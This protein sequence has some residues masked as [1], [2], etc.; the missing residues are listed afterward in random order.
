M[1]TAA[2]VVLA[3]APDAFPWNGAQTLKAD[4]GTSLTWTVTRT[5]G[6]VLIEGTHSRWSV[7]HVAKLD[8]TPVSTVKTSNGKT[9]RIAYREGGADFTPPGGKAVLKI[10]A[11]G[12]WDSE[13]L[14][15]RLAGIRWSK[16]KQL[17]FNVLDVDSSDGSV[18]PMLAEGLGPE[19]CGGRACQGV[20][21]TL[22]GWRRP[23]GPTIIF[24]YG[25]DEAAAYLATVN[26]GKELTSR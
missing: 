15:A 7:V 17:R 8:G 25:T 11:N 5:Q 4:D 12:L 18:Y 9:A 1:L 16:G 6:E 21:L 20:K 26:D 19:Q 23:F 24:R 13:S 10:D 22:D 2:V 3:A 14:D